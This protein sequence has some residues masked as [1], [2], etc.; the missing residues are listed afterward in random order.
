LAIQLVLHRIGCSIQDITRSF[1]VQFSEQAEITFQGA[2]ERITTPNELF[3]KFL[4]GIFSGHRITSSGKE[5][6]RDQA[7]GRKEPKITSP[8]NSQHPIERNPIDL[9]F[10]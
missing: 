6:R 7:C 1:L 4:N 5:G 8:S 10:G 2:T 9:E 3:A